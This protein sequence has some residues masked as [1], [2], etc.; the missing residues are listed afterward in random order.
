[1]NSRRNATKAT[2][3]HAVG[4]NASHWVPPAVAIDPQERLM[5]NTIHVINNQILQNLAIAN[6][7]LTEQVAR[8]VTELL[9][10]MTHPNTSPHSANLREGKDRDHAFPQFVGC[11]RADSMALG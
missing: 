10:G 3:T 8:R 2:W 4:N 6:Q 1:M 9:A 11:C 5:I 7:N